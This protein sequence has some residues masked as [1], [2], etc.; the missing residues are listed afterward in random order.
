MRNKIV[1]LLGMTAILALLVGPASAVN[2]VTNGDFEGAFVGGL[3]A[4]WTGWH[5]CDGTLGPCT[6]IAYWQMGGIAPTPL[7]AQR[8]LGGAMQNSTFNGGVFQAVS[9]QS[10]QLYDFGVDASFGHIPGGDP[11][12]RWCKVGYDLTGQTTDPAAVNW[13]FV[14]PDGS[15]Y[16][17]SLQQLASVFQSVVSTR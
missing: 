1:V 10:G 4:N 14:M 15:P 12:N 16:S 5:N 11:A 7:K 13:C 3:A 9:V 2:L 8:V 17:S 6:L